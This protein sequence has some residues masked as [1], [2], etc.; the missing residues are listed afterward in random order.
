MMINSISSS[1]HIIKNINP[2]EYINVDNIRLN[3]IEYSLNRIE[4]FKIEDRNFIPNECNILYDI[5]I[6]IQFLGNDFIP[7]LNCLTSR[8]SLVILIDIYIRHITRTKNKFKY[9][10]FNE[11]NINKLNYEN[12]NSIIFK[13][14]ENEHKLLYK[15][16]YLNI[17]KY[18][19]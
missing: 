10:V 13:L 19:I 2:I 15:I 5:I 1:F 14:S 4:K 17:F 7:K 11:N 12:L 6:L 18:N 8:S 16:I 9:I 3:L